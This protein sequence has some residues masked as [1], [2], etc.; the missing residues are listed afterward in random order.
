MSKDQ[1]KENEKERESKIFVLQRN[2]RLLRWMEAYKVQ[3][4][5]TLETKERIMSP[6]K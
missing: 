6:K 5:E 3:D 2:C 4:L 1:E